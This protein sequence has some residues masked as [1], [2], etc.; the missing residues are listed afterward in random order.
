M[1]S[2]RAGVAAVAIVLSNAAVAGPIIYTQ[3]FDASGSFYASQNDTGPGANGN[4]ATVYD[5][6]SFSTAQSITDVHW[7]GTYFNPP[8]QGPITRF[9]VAFYGD[10]GGQPGTALRTETFGGT[11]GETFVNANNGFPVFTYSVDLSS[12]FQVAGNTTYWLSI[13][14]DLAFPPEWGWG[15]G[16]GG[17]GTSWQVFFGSGSPLST[18]MAFDL[19]SKAVPEPASVMLLAVA[20]LAFGLAR[21]PGRGRTSKGS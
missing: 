15:S 13:V 20:C 12:A 14:P 10:A 9:T 16:T 2:R 4:F 6:F 18:D 3:P 19:T 5:N 21:N 8:V 11:A 7:T 17:D 1:M